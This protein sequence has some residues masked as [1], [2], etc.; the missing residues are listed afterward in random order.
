MSNPLKMFRKHQKS[1]MIVFG[2]LLMVSFL[3][4]G[5]CLQ[6]SNQQQGLELEATVAVSIGGNKLYDHDMKNMREAHVQTLKFLDAVLQETQANKGSPKAESIGR[7]DSEEDLVRTEVLARRAADMGIVVTDDAVFAYLDQLSDHTIQKKE[8][9]RILNAATGGRLSVNQV[10]DQLRKELLAQ[11]VLVLAGSGLSALPPGQAYEYF[12]RLNRRVKAEVLPLKVEDYIGQVK[13]E[14]TEAQIQALYDEGKLRYPHPDSPDPGFKRRKRIAFEYLHFDFELFVKEE[15]AKITDEQIKQEYDERIARGD[16]KELELPP[17]DD[18]QLL[19]KTD[20]G[21]PPATKPEDPAGNTAPS[22]DKPA[23]DGAPAPTPPEKTGDAPEKTEAKPAP[24]GDKE[25][26]A[27][28][29]P[30]QPSGKT[31]KEEESSPPKDQGASRLLPNDVFVSIVDDEAKPDDKPAEVKPEAAEKPA[32]APADKPAEKPATESPEK[33]A[34]STDKSEGKP[35]DK[36]ATEEPKSE[37][38]KDP[39]DQPPAPAEPKT[40]EQKPEE[41]SKPVEEPKP[42]PASKFQ[43]L[44]KVQ[45]QIRRDLASQP[46]QQRLEE[47]LKQAQREFRDYSIAYKRWIPVGKVNSAVAKPAS[48]DLPAL[49]KRLNVTSG[50][51]PLA[52]ELQIGDYELG[53]SAV[54]DQRNFQMIPFAA[55]AYGDS[56][57]LYTPREIGFMRNV[58]FLYWKTDEQEAYV[59]E[60]SKIRDEVVRA[61]KMREALTLAKQ[62]AAKKATTARTSNRTLKETFGGADGSNVIET[63]EFTWMTRG[64]TA[65]GGPGVPTPSRVEGVQSAG[66]DFMETVFSLHVGE[67]G[68]TV[69]H[70]LTTVYVVRAISRAPSEEL[71]R[72]QF[73]ATGI[74]RDVSMIAQLELRRVY[75]EWYQN[76]EME[77]NVKWQREP[78]ASSRLE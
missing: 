11:N 19:P 55:I 34:A 60:L 31:N 3:V 62:D 48:P 76:L 29:Q 68:V 57:L 58:D 40:G 13:A 18:R 49:A 77:M 6:M 25:V 74:S 73:L 27:K 4:G 66:P 10:L 43:P 44:E 63:N 24:V 71:L 15:M 50:K 16:F 8:F 33:P 22:P 37:P 32:D 51:T 39:A 2:V 53:Q 61:W 56:S 52:D 7:S 69:N 35:E 54:F 5:S 17:E 28:P 1:L 67:V 12:N 45:D 46:A 41:D 70:P 65:F 47:A 38:K 75:Y 20:G 26:P 36:P 72:D 59:P 9:T 30:E 21:T 14:P 64:A 23:D 78:V 42:E